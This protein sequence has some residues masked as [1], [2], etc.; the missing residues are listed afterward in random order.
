MNRLIRLGWKFLHGPRIYFIYSS[1]QS[2]YPSNSFESMG[3]SMLSFM[4]GTLNVCIALSP[5]LFMVAY[6]R[7]L[8]NAANILNLTKFLF[9]Y[10]SVAIG[11]RTLGRV[12]NEDYC[13]FADLLLLA[14]ENEDMKNNS[15]LRMQLADYDYQ[16]FAAPIDFKARR[17]DSLS[18]NTYI[19]EIPSDMNMLLSP[20]RDALAYVLVNT[21]GRRMVYPGSVTLFNMLVSNFVIEARRK[22]I[23][24][25]GG[26]RAIIETQDANRIDTMFVDNRGKSDNGN[27]LVVTCEGNA[28]FYETG[29]MV[30][31]LSLG[32]SVLGW[33]HPGFAESSGQPSPS[34]IK[35]AVDSVMQYAIEKLGFRE[36]DITIYSWSIGGFPGTWAAANYQNIKGLILDA[37]FDDLLPLAEARM[38]KSCASI[39]KYAVRTYINLPVAKQLSLYNGPVLLI[40]RSQDEM[41]ITSEGGTDEE[42]K[43]SNRANYLLKS[44]IRSRHPG[45]IDDGFE[46]YVDQW[47]SAEVIE[48]LTITTDNVNV[49]PS[50]SLNHNYS[51]L[52]EYERIQLIFKICSKYFVDYDSTHNVPLEPLL[53]NIPTS[54]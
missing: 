5:I 41:I 4:K 44:L 37:T 42:R 11:T 10:Y 50:V 8:L 34:E 13:K 2:I 47:L 26:K 15:H 23:V 40:R 17:R 52:S 16:I 43:A 24:E 39:V 27:I 28:G 7:S 33:N 35:N 48:R 31:P 14:D 6:N 18:M 25:K 36:E 1:P 30:T 45:L 21:F 20:F 22:L 46:I 12:T 38:P 32:Y 51:E 19:D 49:K 29:I 3:D 54:V 53:F 9:V